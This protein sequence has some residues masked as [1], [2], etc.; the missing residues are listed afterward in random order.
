[1]QTRQF[2]DQELEILILA[3]RYWR[4][5]RGQV[6]RKTDPAFGPDEIDVLLSKLRGTLTTD[7]L[8]PL[9]SS[10]HGDPY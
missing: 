2:D 6:A 9:V 3:L 5:Q 7:P 1:M 8:K 4:V 10:T